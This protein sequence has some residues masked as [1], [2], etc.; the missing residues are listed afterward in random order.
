M[1]PSNT[2]ARRRK[3]QVGE[4]LGA[5]LGASRDPRR[6]HRLLALMKDDVV[7]P[8]RLVNIKADPRS[9]R[10]QLSRRA[11]ACA[12][13]LSPRSP[14]CRQRGRS[15]QLSGACRGRQR[16]GQPADSQHGD[17]RRQYVPAPALLVFPQRHGTACPNPNGKSM[18]VEGDNR[19]AAILG[20]D[21]PA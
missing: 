9:A 3:K 8:K 12:S 14:S 10:H 6:R 7:T 17:D 16:S 20:N 19:Y 18:V 4:L 13:A 5:E 11:A 21:G 1:Q 15:T 2:S